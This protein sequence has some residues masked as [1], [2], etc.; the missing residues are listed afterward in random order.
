M[1]PDL[2]DQYA[3]LP[4]GNVEKPGEQWKILDTN[5][6]PRLIKTHL[7]R[8]LLPR[9]VSEKKAKVIRGWI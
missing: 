4:E 8:E 6:N 3:K 5:V 9:G 1:T 7:H 2:L